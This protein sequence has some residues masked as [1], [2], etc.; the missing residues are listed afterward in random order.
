MFSLIMFLIFFYGWLADDAYQGFAQ[1]VNLF[2]GGVFGYNMNER[3]NTST[4]ILFEFVMMP[5][6]AITGDLFWSAIIINMLSSG[7]ALYMLLFK[8]CNTRTK[9]VVTGIVVLVSYYFLSFCTSGL[10][11][12]L[13]FMFSAFFLYLY[14]NTKDWTFSKLLLLSL[15]DSGLLLCRL[16]LAIIF[17][18]PT[19]YVYLFKRKDKSV[20]KMLL[21]GIIGLIPVFAWLLFSLWYYGVPFPTTFYA[22]LYAGVPK[23]DMIKHGIVY[24][25]INVFAD[26]IFSMSMM[27]CMAKILSN[28]HISYKIFGFSLIVRLLY[29]VYIGGDFMIGRMLT[30]VYFISIYLFNTISEEDKIVNSVNLMKHKALIIGL[31]LLAPV[32]SICAEGVSKGLLY[33]ALDERGYYINATS[34][35]SK[36]NTTPTASIFRPLV[37]CTAIDG[38]EDGLIKDIQDKMADGYKGVVF[39]EVLFG[40]IKCK[41]KGIYISD[42]TALGDMLLANMRMTD[43]DPDKWRVGHSH[44]TIPDGYKESLQTDSNLITDPS[45]HEYYDIILE[46]TRGDLYSPDRLQLIWDFNTGKY[47]YLLDEYYAALDAAKA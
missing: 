8:A 33:Y 47:D 28:K 23:F 4:C 10:E 35:Q 9:V 15:I 3:V 17:F 36:F 30:D 27:Y 24:M 11:N 25:I 16:D 43:Y 34:I 2:D 31:L 18:A 46:L 40:T 45:L 26:I 42:N 29:I 22:K 19:A 12:S 41:M 14:I 38:Y 13:V 20:V 5:F 32:S 39:D 7:A 44:R 1:V 21:A 37:L 6:Y